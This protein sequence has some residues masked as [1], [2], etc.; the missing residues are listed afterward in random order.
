M[1]KAFDLLIF[2]VSVLKMVPF[3]SSVRCQKMASMSGLLPWQR[4]LHAHTGGVWFVVVSCRRSTPSDSSLKLAAE[5]DSWGWGVGVDR[6]SDEKIPGMAWLG[7]R[8]DGGD[9]GF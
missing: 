7:S 8:K 6:V 9:S 1:K 3:T 5:L 2:N 4:L